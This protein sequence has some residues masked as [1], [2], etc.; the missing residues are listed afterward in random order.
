MDRRAAQARGLLRVADD[1]GGIPPPNGS[2][3]TSGGSNGTTPPSSSVP[4]SVAPTLMPPGAPAVKSNEAR[5]AMLRLVTPARGQRYPLV[6]VSS[7]SGSAT[8]RIRL[9]ELVELVASSARAGHRPA[10]RGRAL[11][12]S[13]RIVSCGSLRRGRCRRCRGSRLSVRRGHI[14]ATQGARFGGLPAFKRASFSARSCSAA[15][16]R[17]RTVGRSAR[18]RGPRTPRGA[19]PEAGRGGGPGT[20]SG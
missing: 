20:P 4:S 13:R 7:G 10:S 12:R 8:L 19:P 3:S 9:V 6:K 5:V 15:R 18:A 2:G 16:T 1:S 14:H 17:A 11:S